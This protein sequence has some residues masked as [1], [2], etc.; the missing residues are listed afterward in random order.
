MHPVEVLEDVAI[1]RYTDV[2]VENRLILWLLWRM[3]LLLE[4]LLA[5]EVCVFQ[6]AVESN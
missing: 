1:V 3:S 4:Q 6:S 5:S 2:Y